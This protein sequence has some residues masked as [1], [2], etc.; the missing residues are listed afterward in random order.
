MSNKIYYFQYGFNTGKV[1][2]SEYECTKNERTNSVRFELKN[3]S[4][5]ELNICD[6]KNNNSIDY[7]KNDEDVFA[8]IYTFNDDVNSALDAIQTKLTKSLN[9]I[10]AKF[11]FYQKLTTDLAAKQDEYKE[12]YPSGKKLN[13]TDVER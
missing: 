8:Y 7:Y 3:G 2:R 10:K 5:I 9:D 11:D 6:V 12:K 4:G 13:T 1:R